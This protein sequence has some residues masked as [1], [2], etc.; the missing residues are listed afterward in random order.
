MSEMK[1]TK[2]NSHKEAYELFDYE[3]VEQK[4]GYSF[5]N[6]ALLYQ[7][8]VR[9]SFDNEHAEL[10]SAN[11]ET[12]EFIGDKVIDI[13]VVKALIKK[14]AVI[15]NSIFRLDKAS[16][17]IE[18]FAKMLNTKSTEK[19]LTEIKAGI[20]CGKN[21]AA[22]TDR[23]G[24]S[25]N[26]IMGNGDVQ[27]T[28]K[29]ELSVKEDLLEAIVGAVAIDTDWNFE[30]LEPFVSSLLDL[31]NKLDFSSVETDYVSAL[32]DAWIKLYGRKPEYIVEKFGDM[33]RVRIPHPLSKAFVFEGEITSSGLF[34]VSEGENEKETRQKCAKKAY[35]AV[36]STI[37]RYDKIEKAIGQINF[38]RSVN[39]L[40]E[41]AQKKII[42]GLEY[43]ISESAE[44]TADGNRK[45]SCRC[46][47][48]D[49]KITE[50]T[51]AESKMQAKKDAAFLMLHRLITPICDWFICDGFAECIN[52]NEKEN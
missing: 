10:Y 44:M 20:V 42:Y 31:E 45:W 3:G 41:L 8:F 22:C 36:V 13:V 14:N 19:E 30:V 40:Q 47:V 32:E 52:L 1:K 12:L 5:K 34:Y 23:L 11:N 51:I 33:V 27:N 4:L 48:R 24:I 43:D 29:S 50:S 7:A 18:A 49:P 26:L 21:L 35:E 38:E 17:K 28:A 16:D 25:E 15:K 2:F 6:R 46:T 37:E 39:Q 9:R